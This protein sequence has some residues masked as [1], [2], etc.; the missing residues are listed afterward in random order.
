MDKAP[1]PSGWGLFLIIAF[2][3]FLIWHGPWDG[4]D[5]I[6]SDAIQ[7]GTVDCGQDPKTLSN[8]QLELCIDIQ[9][10]RKGSDYE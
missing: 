9:S 6:P 10:F 5:Y 2:L 1:H 3:A 7:H 4:R 8:I